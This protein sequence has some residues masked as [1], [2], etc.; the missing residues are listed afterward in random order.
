MLGQPGLLA[1][2][3]ANSTGTPTSQQ[4]S[5]GAQY[6][7]GIPP[8]PSAYAAAI[9]AASSIAQAQATPLVNGQALVQA[10]VSS[11]LSPGAQYSVGIPKAPDAYLSKMA[12]AAAQ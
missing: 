8:V 3:S 1:V 6:S 10:Q 4:L 5:P 9:A 2:G 12:A 11:A 7:V